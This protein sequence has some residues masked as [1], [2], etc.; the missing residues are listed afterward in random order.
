MTRP[1]PPELREKIAKNLA[2]V[3]PV[4][5]PAVRLVLLVCWLLALLL[6]VPALVGVRFNATELGPWLTWGASLAQLLVGGALVYL[7]LR[8]GIPGLAAPRAVVVASLVAAGTM[9]GAVALLTYARCPCPDAGFFGGVACWGSETALG[10]P[11]LVLTLWLVARAYPLSPR[12]A[13]LLG[14]VGAGVAADGVQHLLCPI[15]DLRHVLLWHGGAVVALGLLGWL[16][17]W[18]WEWRRLQ[19]WKAERD[20]LP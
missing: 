6:L 12:R 1:L 17:G 5:P 2:P 9:E 15:S 18:L 20:T 8:E 3:R 13:G 16:V 19:Q 7:A 10:I 14:G 4:A 11:A